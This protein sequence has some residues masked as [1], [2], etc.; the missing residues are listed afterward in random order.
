LARETTRKN[1]KPTRAPAPA[2][3][4][5]RRSKPLLYEMLV[6]ALRTEILNGTYPVNTP[7]PSEQ[8]LVDRFGVSRH[9]VRD[10][11]RHLR[12]LGLVESR[13]GKGTLVLKPGGPQVYVHQVSSISDL[14]D[15]NVE[16]RYD[17]SAQPVPMTEKF[18]QR[19]GVGTDGTWLRID[20]TRFDQ[21]SG[22]PICAVEI[23]IPGRFSGISRLLGRRSGP[24]YSL[25]EVVYGESINEVEQELR[26]IPIS[27]KMAQ[28]LEIEPGET[29]VEIKRIYR[30]LDKQIAEI[31]FNYYRAVN[32]SFSMTLRRVR[33]SA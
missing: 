26:A 12:D 17:D 8:A 18:A 28:R 1:E 24:I 3:A 9:T 13:Q 16:S 20:G 23:F 32:F 4:A 14:H 29:V 33:G 6:K 15:Y 27:A 5:A 10:A 25:I 31:T 22:R 7:L 30:L 19:L 2:P 21:Q 11:L